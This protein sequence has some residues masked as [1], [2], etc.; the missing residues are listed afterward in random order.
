MR[1]RPSR[2]T[3]HTARLVAFT[4]RF[5]RNVDGATAV[6]FA[7]VSA[8]FFLLMLG[9]MTV[10]MQHLTLHSLEQGVADASR[11]LRTG[12]AQKAGL[13]VGDFRTLVCQSA[14]SNISCDNRLVIHIKS[15]DSFADLS[16]PT[17]CMTNGNLTPAAGLGTDGIRTASG[18]A[19]TA[20]L[21]T[22]CYDWELGSSLWQSVWNV[23]SP[24]PPTQGKTILSAATAFR[25][26][27]F[28]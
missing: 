23:L 6:E 11:K 15:G 18:N 9:I 10:G 28:E 16:P 20:V 26:E 17:N 8:P 2:L 7:I 24:M 19:S 22:A 25:S 4:R 14:G 13:S 27:P 1:P 3:I 12:E 5:R 21:V